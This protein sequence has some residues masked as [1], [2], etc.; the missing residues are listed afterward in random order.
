MTDYRNFVEDIMNRK[1]SAIF[2][3]SERE[4]KSAEKRCVK[5]T[6]TFLNGLSSNIFFLIPACLAETS[7][8][9][10]STTIVRKRDGYP[11]LKQRQ[12]G[13]SVE[14]KQDMCSARLNMESE[15]EQEEHRPQYSGT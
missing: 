3:V 15:D 10:T 9:S 13:L 2:Q 8:T 12:A 11:K 6:R 4:T 5:P 7:L 14:V 1:I